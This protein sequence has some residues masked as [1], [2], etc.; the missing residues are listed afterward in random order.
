L[1]ARHAS[2]VY[3]ALGLAPSLDDHRRVLAVI[4]MPSW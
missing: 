1:L 3:D 4:R 2:Q